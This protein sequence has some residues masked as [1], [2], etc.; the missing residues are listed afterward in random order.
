MST[1]KDRDK[2]V[3]ADWDIYWAGK[4]K[5]GHPMYDILASIYRKLVVKNILNHFIKKNYAKGS[6]VLH[7]GCGSGQV[8]LDIRDYVDI[9]ALD[10]STNALSIYR[11]VHGE[12]AKTVQGSIFNLPFEDD[13]FDGVYNLG[14]MEHFTKDEIQAILKEFQRVVRNDGRILVLWPP[15]YGFTV[16]VLDS[17]HFIMNRIFRMNVKLHPDEISRIE[18]RKMAINV[19]SEAGLRDIR[20]NFGIRDFFTQVVL[21]GKVHKP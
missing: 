16:F 8:D 20:Y 5:S 9:T 10:I 18:S 15:K 7:A 12:K 6:K 3:Q 4:D 11:K 19:F 13:S 1:T 17:A 2:E 21:S 14:V